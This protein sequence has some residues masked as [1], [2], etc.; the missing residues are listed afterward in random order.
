MYCKPPPYRWSSIISKLFCLL[1][2]QRFSFRK[3]KKDGGMDHLSPN[4][5]TES[6]ISTRSSKSLKRNFSN[7]K[8]PY[9]RFMSAGRGGSQIGEGGGFATLEID[10]PSLKS[11]GCVY[12]YVII[13]TWLS[14]DDHMIH[15]CRDLMSI[16]EYT[17]PESRYRDIDVRRHIH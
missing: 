4:M 6:I 5:D 17:P 8:T 16:S 7:R 10:T 14:H 15:V 1:Y 12:L 2:E 9:V 13:V 3:N 11:L